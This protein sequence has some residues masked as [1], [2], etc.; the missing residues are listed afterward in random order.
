[1]SFEL[2]RTGT[3]AVALLAAMFLAPRPA[4]AQ[5]PDGNAASILQQTKHLDL[6]FAPTSAASDVST[7]DASSPSPM[8]AP[9]SG[10]GIG[11]KVGPLFSSFRDATNSDNGVFSRRTG[12]MGGL[13]IGGNR[14]GVV[15]AAMEV[16][17]VK[18]STTQNGEDVDL[19]S[20]Q[21]PV[22]ARINIG[23]SSTSGAQV[24]V[25]VG[26]AVDWRFKAHSS[27]TGSIKDQTEGYDLSLVGGVGVEITR[28]II[29]G[30]YIE[31]FRN[32]AK[33]LSDTDKIKTRSFAVLFGVRFN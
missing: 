32:V 24:Y 15:G 9:A 11:V 27:I 16:N 13:F 8:R 7:D 20:I 31:G 25:L 5:N 22:L 4:L 23:S 26:P 30:R 21:I 28:F 2:R 18:R 12:F 29:E 33:D 3:A 14:G 17:V 1:M 19:Y 6:S 10:V